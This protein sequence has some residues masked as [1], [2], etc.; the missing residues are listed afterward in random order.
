MQLV[1]AHAKMVEKKQ[2]SH[3]TTCDNMSKTSSV[4]PAHTTTNPVRPS[5]P[6]SSSSFISPKV[7]FALFWLSICYRCRV[8]SICFSVLVFLAPFVSF[9]PSFSI[10]HVDAIGIETRPASPFT[11][12]DACADGDIV[13]VILGHLG[14]SRQQQQTPGERVSNNYN[15]R[16]S[17]SPVSHLCHSCCCCW[18]VL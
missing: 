7:I 11:N 3:K 12:V 4:F 2:T 13:V 15:G 16:V 1:V 5:R 18:T 17:L 14:G 6:V 10:V 8:C 9:P